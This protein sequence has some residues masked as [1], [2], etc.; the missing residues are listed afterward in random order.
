MHYGGIR[1]GF[2]DD[3]RLGYDY[4]RDGKIDNRD[5]DDYWDDIYFEEEMNRKRE[6]INEDDFMDMDEDERREALEDVGL[7]PDDYD[8]L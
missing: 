5:D 3:S 4:N 2:F 8:Y 6:D 1:M 7:D